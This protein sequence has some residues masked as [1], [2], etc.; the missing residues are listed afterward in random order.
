MV[1]YA[2][3]NNVFFCLLTTADSAKL[4]VPPIVI[5]GENIPPSHLKSSSMDLAFSLHQQMDC[6]MTTTVLSLYN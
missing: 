2:T 3:L 5:T 1:S 4:I 6:E